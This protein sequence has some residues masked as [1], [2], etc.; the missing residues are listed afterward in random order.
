MI[1][2][3]LYVAFV[4]ATTVLILAPGPAV[5]LIVANS[6]AYGTKRAML[7]VIGISLATAAYLIVTFFSM[8]SFLLLLAEWFN[9]LRWAGAIYLVWLGIRL[10]MKKHDDP[11][12]TAV[13][14]ASPTKLLVQGFLVNATNPKLLI[15]YGAF[16]PQFVD[17]SRDLQPQLAILCATFFVIALTFDSLYAVLAGRVRVLFRTSRARRWIDRISGTLLIGAGV[18]LALVRR[19]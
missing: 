18:G 14:V 4:L 7:S 9:L 12:A 15:F 8:A 2:P 10:W 1:D 19:S 5:S 3:G 16:F 11:D 13:R 17:S 6:L